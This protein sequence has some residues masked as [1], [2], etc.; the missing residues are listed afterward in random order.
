MSPPPSGRSSIVPSSAATPLLEVVWFGAASDQP[1]AS[2]VTTG[3]VAVAVDGDLQLVGPL[4]QR[5]RELLDHAQ[6]RERLA[7]LTGSPRSMLG[8][9]GVGADLLAQQLELE[10][11]RRTRGPR[12]R[13]MPGPGAVRSVGVPARRLWRSRS[14]AQRPSPGRPRRSAASR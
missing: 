11:D 2:T 9:L 3:R 7:G 12:P 10:R 5:G 14:S 4:G 8:D 13:S 6:D 1:A